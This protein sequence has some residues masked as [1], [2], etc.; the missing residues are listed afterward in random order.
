MSNTRSQIKCSNYVFHGSTPQSESLNK[1]SRQTYLA[2]P[3]FMLTSNPWGIVR[4]KPVVLK[5]L[6]FPCVDISPDEIEAMWNELVSVGMI[7]E[8]Q[9]DGETWGWIRKW[10]KFN[11]KWAKDPQLWDGPMPPSWKTHNPKT[12]QRHVQGFA[13]KRDVPPAPAME[14]SPADLAKSLAEKFKMGR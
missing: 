5:G 14:G 7:E 6:I 12:S 1:C 4:L 9:E 3:W 2:W 10:Y 11:P 13:W 8:W